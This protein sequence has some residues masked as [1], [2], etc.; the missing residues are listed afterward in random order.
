MTR[1]RAWLVRWGPDLALLGISLVVLTSVAA[2]F[3]YSG[4]QDEAYSP[5]NHT[6]SALGE[7]GV[8]ELALLFN[9]SLV[10][11]GLLIGL[12]MLSITARSASLTG[13]GFGLLG[14][15][16]ALAMACVGLFPVDD[17]ERHIIVAAIAFVLILVAGVWFAVWVFR[18]SAPYPH[19]LGWFALWVATAMVAFFLLPAILQPGLTFEM[20]F[21]AATPRPDFLLDSLLEWIAVGSAWAWVAALAWND[22]LQHK[23][24]TT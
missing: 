8:S 2:A 17:L 7:R 10:V 1:V 11:S 13:R 22:R 20:E 24:D 16:A 14:T 6:L 5:L 21:T 4:S 15:V 12:F 9:I 23:G 3:V 18:G 19:W